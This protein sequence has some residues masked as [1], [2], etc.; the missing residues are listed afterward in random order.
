MASSAPPQ[1]KGDEKI[2]DIWSPVTESTSAPISV[3]GFDV[4]PKDEDV[5]NNDSLEPSA[6]GQSKACESS[7]RRWFHREGPEGQSPRAPSVGA[8]IEAHESIQADWNMFPWSLEDT[9]ADPAE[10]NIGFP[11]KIDQMVSD[12]P[13]VVQRKLEDRVS[14]LEAQLKN[15]HIDFWIM[16]HRKSEE[17]MSL[18]TTMSKMCMELISTN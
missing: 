6:I 2:I 16:S 11:S 12:T 9:S 4:T 10:T 18:Q 3:M 7:R 5:D 14:S 17:I 15:A 13:E 1:Y 8:P